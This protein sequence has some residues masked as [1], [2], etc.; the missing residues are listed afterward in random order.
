MRLQREENFYLLELLLAAGIAAIKRR[1]Q[2]DHWFSRNHEDVVVE[3]ANG[4]GWQGR[5]S[6]FVMPTQLLG[7]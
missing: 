3:P 7:F 1:H 4:L 2:L 6:R 5:E